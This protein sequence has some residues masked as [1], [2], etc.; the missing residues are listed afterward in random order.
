MIKE[1]EQ[2]ENKATK[3]VADCQSMLAARTRDAAGDK[4]KASQIQELTTKLNAARQELA[5][6]KKLSGNHNEKLRAK[7]LVQE[8]ADKLKEAEAELEKATTACAPILE[9][10]C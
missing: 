3:Q 2:H 9:E 7:A 1:L 10:K 8:V 6:A 4:E 5:K